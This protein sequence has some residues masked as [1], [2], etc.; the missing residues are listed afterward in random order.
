MFLDKVF[1]FDLFAILMPV[2]CILL[3]F[4]DYKNMLVKPKMSVKKCSFQRVKI[5]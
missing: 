1:S 2:S 3:C 4:S 5:F